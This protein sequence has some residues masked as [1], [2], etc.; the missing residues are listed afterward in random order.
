[1]QGVDGF[2]SNRV[3]PVSDR[4]RSKVITVIVDDYNNSLAHQTYILKLVYMN[5]D[6]NI[7]RVYMHAGCDCN[8]VIPV[9]FG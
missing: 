2:D 7:Y 3:I 8:R 1:M 9:S 4:P 6:M 5:S